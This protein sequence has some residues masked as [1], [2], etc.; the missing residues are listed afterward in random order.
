[1]LYHLQDRNQIWDNVEF[2]EDIFLDTVAQVQIHIMCVY[3]NF[4][5]LLKED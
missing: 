5:K 3:L 1:M 2:W 4:S